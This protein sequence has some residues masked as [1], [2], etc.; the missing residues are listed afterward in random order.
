M[1]N[2]CSSKATVKKKQTIEYEKIFARQIMDKKLVPRIV[3]KTKT[4]KQNQNQL[5]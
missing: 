4:K 3:T 1:K 2:F 5:L